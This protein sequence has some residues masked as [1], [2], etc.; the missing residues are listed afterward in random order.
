MLI[1][2]HGDHYMVPPTAVTNISVTTPPAGQLKKG[3]VNFQK[4]GV[5]LTTS[6]TCGLSYTYIDICSP[7]IVL[8][9]YYPYTSF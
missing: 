6:H 9:H 4:L 1:L 5:I 7:K 3:I 8:L 2:Q